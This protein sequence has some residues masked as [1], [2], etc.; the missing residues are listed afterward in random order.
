M[1]QHHDPTTQMLVPDYNC[2]HEHECGLCLTCDSHGDCNCECEHEHEC[3]LCLTC[4]S[5]VTAI[6]S[7][8]SGSCLTCDSMVTAIVSMSSGFC[9]TCDSHRDC[10]CECD[11]E[12]E[13]GL[14]LI[15]DSHGECRSWQ[16]DGGRARPMC[17]TS[18]IRTPA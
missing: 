8:S 13:C 15:C 4:D 14:C 3:V 17:T 11:H 6:V 9:L 10:D 5:M 2:E 7:M 18:C 16:S 1:M 12:H